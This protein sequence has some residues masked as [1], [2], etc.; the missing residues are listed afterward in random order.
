MEFVG[1]SKRV[2]M[3]IIISLVSGLGGLY[4]IVMSYL[5]KDWQKAQLSIGIPAVVYIF[6]IW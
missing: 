3:G 2:L 5:L 4:L 1:P 6:Y